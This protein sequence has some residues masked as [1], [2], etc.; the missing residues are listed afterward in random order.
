MNEEF[1]DVRYITRWSGDVIWR[2]GKKNFNAVSH[3]RARPYFRIQHGRGE[4]RARLDCS[5]SNRKCGTQSSKL[6]HQITWL[7]ISR[8]RILHSSQASTL[9]T[10]ITRVSGY[11]FFPFIFADS[12]SL[13]TYLVNPTTESAKIWIRFPKQKLLNTTWIR[14]RVDAEYGPNPYPMK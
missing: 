4:V 6:R 1:L 13:H 10:L 3:N 7:Y 5:F 8:P 2:T 12:P 11:L 9:F 14:Y